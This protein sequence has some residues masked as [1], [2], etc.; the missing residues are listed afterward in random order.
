MQ[1]TLSEPAPVTRIR[2]PDVPVVWSNGH[3]TAILTTEGEIKILNNDQA[4]MIIHKKHALVCH[5][6]YTKSKLGLNEF[7]A[8]DIL[9]LF[10]FV[11]PA[12][13]TVPTPKGICTSLG[14]SPPQ[15]FEDYPL[16][17][18]E[19]T[20]TLLK[21]LQNDPHQKKADPLKIAA[22]MGM[23]G[24]GWLWTPFIFAA[25]GQDYDSKEIVHSK[26]AMNI[27]RH[28]PEWAEEAPIPPP[29][30]F[31]VSSEEA[32]ERLSKMLGQNT[33]EEA[34]PQQIE[35]TKEISKTFAPVNEAENPHVILA[36]AGTGTGKT[37]GYLAPAS[38]WSEKNTGTVWISTYTKNLQRQIDQ[39]LSRLYPEDAI[40]EAYIA[41]RKGRE[42]YLCLLNLENTA[43]AAGTARNFSQVVS[44]GIM[45]RWAAAT[46]DGDLSGADFPGWLTGIMGYA[47][48]LG[49]AD[50]RGECIYSAC[51][52][53]KKC[54]G[55]RSIRKSK[56]ARIVVANHAL[57]MIQS[58][59]AMPGEDLPTRYI[60]DEGHHLFDSADSAFSAHLTAK[61]MSDLR[62]WILGAEGGR[63]SRARGLKK[64][65]EDL[66][67]A[68]PE[69]LSLLNQVLEEAR[70]LTAP[71]WTKR[72][73]EGDPF[74]AA[75]KF[76]TCIY[77]QVFARSKN[78]HAPYSLET[79]LYPAAPDLLQQAKRLK[80]QLKNL[81]KPM[82]Q[83]ADHFKKILTSDNGEMESDTRKRFEAIAISLNRRSQMTLQ[84]WIN[85]LDNLQKGENSDVFV[86]WLQIERVDGRTYDVGFYR[87]YVDP[88]KPFAASIKLH[89]H[90]MAVTSATL[91]D[92][93]QI[94]NS[95]TASDTIKNI[96]TNAKSWSMAAQRSGAAYLTENL[97]AK[98]FS[99]P[100]KYNEKTR[101]YIA[102]DI[103]KN[104]ANQVSSAYRA[105]F[106]ASNG[107]ALGLFTAI[108]RLRT[109]YER[110]NEEVESHN[111]PLYSQHIDNM[112]IGT[113]IDMFRDEEHACLLGTDAVRDG[114]DVPGR[115]LRMI[116]FDRV[117][118][119]RPTILHKARRAYYGGR[120]Y[121]EMVTRLKLKQAYGRLIRRADDKGVFVMLDSALPSRLQ[122][123]FPPDVEIIKTGLSDI[124]KEIK[125]FL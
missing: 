19:I 40:K 67:S 121:D 109:V 106:L 76:I 123:A 78:T 105:L 25:H 120:K 31:G 77:K 7:Y 62:R 57:V 16:S 65:I 97:I 3:K 68:S 53:Y 23:Q 9:E 47:N 21:D 85:M 46:K 86:D 13:F 20:Q 103:N 110:I 61:E 29:S 43:A 37:L 60:F 54:F 1:E 55:E 94:D 118:W 45:A 34:R 38:V 64:R 30:H 28:L 50:R 124:I 125:S 33:N 69:A 99:S 12:R 95:E 84:S 71:G 26:T 112:D 39:E 96:N 122:S 41:I 91:R 72:L 115:A 101:I 81:Q 44:A 114:V 59:L 63:T 8:F 113:L 117:P 82:Q 48:T 18:I 98:S 56:H 74:G 2:L 4:R 10:A 14:L 17:L 80:K 107:G 24:R 83:L 119:P 89:L 11:H 92:E 58:A 93:Q 36:E 73:K 108:N 35:Y 52:H 87:H 42:N 79:E 5:A 75:E 116:V 22:A 100:F 27:W 111:I 66:V 88:M 51:D 6:P 102:N 49:L 104:D 32:Q 90:G 70:T 15:N